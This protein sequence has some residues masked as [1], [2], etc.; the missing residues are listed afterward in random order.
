MTMPLP[1]AGLRVLLVEDLMIIAMECEE[2]LGALGCIV[3]GPVGNLNAALRIAREGTFDV[4]ILDVNL[5]GE[6]IFPVAAALQERRIPFA[7]ATGYA[8]SSLPAEWRHAPHL[9]KPLHCDELMRFLKR[10]SVN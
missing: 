8:E 7:F 5:D 9:G 2:L 6:M 10:A 1:F 4:A 3:A